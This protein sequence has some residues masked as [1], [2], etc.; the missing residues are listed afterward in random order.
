MLLRRIIS[1]GGKQQVPISK[2]AHIDTMVK[3]CSPEKNS[4]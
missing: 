1:A 3:V 2:Y 4:D